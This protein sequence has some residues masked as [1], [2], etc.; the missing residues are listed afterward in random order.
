MPSRPAESS[1]VGP[2]P[3]AAH[4]TSLIARV[5]AALPKDGIA[6][7]AATIVAGTGAAQIVGL[8]V[9]P[10]I[11]RLYS[12]ADFGVFAA[13]L[14]LL[15]ILITISCLSYE[16]A[17]PLPDS[18]EAAA[19]VVALCLISTALMCLVTVLLIWLTG[20]ALLAM[21]GAASLAPYVLLLA[22]GQLVGGAVTTMIAWAVRTRAYGEIAANRLAQ[23]LVQAGAQVG[24]GLL[25]AGAAGLFVGTLLAGTA[26]ST[27]LARRAWRSS[28][29]SFRSVTPAGIRAAAVRYRRFPILAT[30]SNLL[31][32]LSLQAPLLLM[33][34]LFGASVGGQFAL[35]QR[36]VALPATLIAGAVGQAYLG[37]AAR[38]SLEHPA[39]LPRPLQADDPLTGHHRPGAVPPCARARPAGVRVHLRRGLGTGGRVRGHPLAHVLPSVRHEPH[40][41]HSGHP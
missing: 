18:D 39:E 19:N 16:L 34:A 26:G 36:M 4:M 9:A 17:I 11:T 6:H 3:V 21:I 2:T 8:V 23:S 37:E 31:N 30:P 14:A 13:A 20:G 40:D 29:A 38:L 7:G 41:P 32:Q 33:V 1:S 25:G 27:R 15:N 12:P 24:F 10:V 35:A 5:R 22:V 28:A